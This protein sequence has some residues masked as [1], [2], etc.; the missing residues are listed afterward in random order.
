MVTMVPTYWV[1]RLWVKGYEHPGITV[2]R[3]HM[4][5]R[6]LFSTAPLHSGVSEGR[7]LSDPLVLP[8]ARGEESFLFCPQYSWVLF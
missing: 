8:P 5:E 2:E 4:L 6:A 3:V 7:L 1:C